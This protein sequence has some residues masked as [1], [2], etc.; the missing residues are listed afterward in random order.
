M[1]AVE[2]SLGNTGRRGK[3]V[4][5]V[6]EHRGQPDLGRGRHVG[7]QGRAGRAGRRQWLDGAGP[8]MRQQHRDIEH[9]HLDLPRQQV[10]NR[11]RRAAIGHMHDVDA[12][13]AP[14]QFCRQMA[15]SSGTGRAVVHFAGIGLGIGDQFLGRIDRQARRRRDDHLHQGDRRQRDQILVLERHVGDHERRDRRRAGG[16]HADRI[17]IGRRLG[18]GGNTDNAA[19]AALVLDHDLLPELADRPRARMRPNMSE[20]PPAANGTYRVIGLARP[21]LR[22]RA[23][24]SH[25]R[26]GAGR[27]ENRPA[28]HRLSRLPSCLRDGPAAIDVEIDPVDVG[29]GIRAQQQGRSGEII[30]LCQAGRPGCAAPALRLPSPSGRDCARSGWRRGPDCSR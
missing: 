19:H 13:G 12:G 28:L 23:G 11:R 20:G 16:V 3:P 27:L 2:N 15:D 14:E 4:P 29:A 6:R 18:G 25:D 24:R 22:P 5:I 7:Q 21:S 30:G 17:A 8:D 9:D 10:L 1:D 26:G